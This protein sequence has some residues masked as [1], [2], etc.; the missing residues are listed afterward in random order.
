[1]VRYTHINNFLE[2][3]LFFYTIAIGMDSRYSY[4]SPNYDRNF[5]FG[6][7]SLLGQHFSV[8]LHPEDIRLCEEAGPKCFADPASLFP[9]T[10]RKHDGKGGYV[11]T[12]WEM[13]GMLDDDGLPQGIFCVGYNITEFVDTQT[14]LDE[15]SS[16][17]DEISFIQ[18]HG[19][20]RPL[21]NIMGITQILSGVQ[22]ASEIPMLTQMLTQSADELDNI[23]H[24]ISNKAS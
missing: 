16:Q 19:V 7:G 22:D 14:K 3:S 18:S 5:S 10:L 4:V 24:Q 20:R 13:Q 8:T 12:Q 15:A 6:K 21:A 23:I 1:M 2:S 17:L 11:I 9:V